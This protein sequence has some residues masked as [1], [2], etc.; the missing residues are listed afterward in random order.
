MLIILPITS[1]TFK[2]SKFYIV[3]SFSA[4]R[5]APKYSSQIAFVIFKNVY[6]AISRMFMVLMSCLPSK[7]YNLKEIILFD[8]PLKFPPKIK[9]ISVTFKKKILMIYE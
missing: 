9:E 7:R 1:R 2:G 8:F 5:Q 3:R 6:G 4:C